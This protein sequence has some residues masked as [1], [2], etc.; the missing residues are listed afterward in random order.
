MHQEKKSLSE[1]ALPA[2]RVRSPLPSLALSIRVSQETH[3]IQE[4]SYWTQIVYFNFSTASVR[5]IFALINNLF[6]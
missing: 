4:I 2:L 3:E 5:N 1:P 6:S